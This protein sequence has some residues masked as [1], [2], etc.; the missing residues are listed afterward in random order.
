MDEEVK[1]MVNVLEKEI[2]NPDQVQAVS[3][4]EKRK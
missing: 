2:K 3:V 4:C 1:H